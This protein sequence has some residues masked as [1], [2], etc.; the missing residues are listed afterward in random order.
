MATPNNVSEANV[1]FALSLFKKLAD[2]N[3]AADVFFSPYS[4]SAALAMV[5]LGARGKTA[6]QMSEVKQVA[7]V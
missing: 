6:A 4:I 3:Q 1:T 7:R 2:A 5:M